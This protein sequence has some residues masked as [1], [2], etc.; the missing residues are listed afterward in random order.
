M[1]GVEDA[2]AGGDAEP[3]LDLVLQVHPGVD[4]PEIVQRDFGMRRGELQVTVRAA[5]AGYLLQQWRVDCSPDRRLDPLI[6]RLCLKDF[7]S[8]RGSKSIEIAPGYPLRRKT[9]AFS[10]KI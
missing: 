2:D 10:P 1:A 5:V 6:H 3:A 7:E 9:P 8:V 4:R